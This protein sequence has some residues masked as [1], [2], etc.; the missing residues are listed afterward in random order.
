M[1]KGGELD[2][3]RFWARGWGEWLDYC[4]MGTLTAVSLTRIRGLKRSSRLRYE[5][6]RELIRKG[7]GK[8]RVGNKGGKKK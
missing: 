1:R 6:A 3:V 7:A 2:W 4:R 8:K 5:D